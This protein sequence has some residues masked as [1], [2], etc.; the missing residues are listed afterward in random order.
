MSE[1]DRPEQDHHHIVKVM[2]LYI[3]NAL[4]QWWCHL[5]LF[6]DDWSV[7]ICQLYLC[8]MYY[9]CELSS[10]CRSDNSIC[11]GQVLSDHS[12]LGN[13]KYQRLVLNWPLL[14]YHQS[15]RQSASAH[16]WKWC[17][18]CGNSYNRPMEYQSQIATT[19]FARHRSTWFMILLCTKQAAL[20]QQVSALTIDGLI[21]RIKRMIFWRHMETNTI[22]SDTLARTRYNNRSSYT[23]FSVCIGMQIAMNS[24]WGQWR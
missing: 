8:S 4:I 14:Q 17:R 2:L 18:V 9:K 15:M 1:K 5:Y 21:Y 13:P 19:I 3:C 22:G 7:P 16:W 23:I 20:L 24:Y 12:D 11:K 6:G 10:R